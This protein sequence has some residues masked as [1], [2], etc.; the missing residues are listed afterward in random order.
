MN[1]AWCRAVAPT[2][3]R[4][5][6][7]MANTLTGRG[8]TSY[9][10]YEG[11]GRCRVCCQPLTPETGWHVHHLLWRS[12]GGP[13][14]IENLVLL[15]PNCHHQLHQQGLVVEKAASREGRS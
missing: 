3:K 7:Q 15:H 8:T 4:L 14:T 2:E 6:A 13:D 1:M 5:A 9:L 11:D 12:Y 10:W